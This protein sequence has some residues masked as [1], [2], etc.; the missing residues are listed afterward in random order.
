MVDE[1]KREIGELS[2]ILARFLDGD[3]LIRVS[4]ASDLITECLRGNGKLLACGNGGSA[5]L[6]QHLVAE[7]VV[8]FKKD[9]PGLAAL[10]LC[11]DTSVLTA[12]ANDLGYEN[13]FSR[14]IEAMGGKGDVLLAMTTS[15]KSGNI[16]RAVEAARALGLRVVYL[17]GKEL[18]PF[19]V[20]VAIS[21]PSDNTARIQEVH[22]LIIHMIARAVEEALTPPDEIR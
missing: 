10:S 15:G 6:A 12:S 19:A 14:Q 13:V 22:T 1:F 7:L 17:C 20:D 4:E 5:A 11:S 9:R 16:A 2:E 21:V 18:P 8:R 3:A